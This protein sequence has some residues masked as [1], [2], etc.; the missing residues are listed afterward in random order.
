[1][2]SSKDRDL[3]SKKHNNAL[4]FEMEAAG[5]MDVFPCLVIRGICDYSDSHKNDAWQKYAAATAAAYAREILLNMS[6]QTPRMP[7]ILEL[8]KT[9]EGDGLVGSKDRYHVVFS[10]SSNSGIQVGHNTGNMTN[11]FGRR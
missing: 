2:K 8:A 1:M 4:C 11:T 3:L 5:L 7:E 6:K 10:G 9:A